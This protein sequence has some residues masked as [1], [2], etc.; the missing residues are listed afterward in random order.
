ML[1][2]DEKWQLY[3]FIITKS[4]NQPQEISVQNEELKIYQI[5]DKYKNWSVQFVYLLILQ[6]IRASY[7]YHEQIFTNQTQIHQQRR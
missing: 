7:D 4:W 6:K 1:K 3:N 5:L 2:P